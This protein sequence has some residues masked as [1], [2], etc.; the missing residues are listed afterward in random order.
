MANHVARIPEGD[1]L[2]N[3]L[4]RAGQPYVREPVRQVLR[5]LAPEPVGGRQHEARLVPGVHERANQ[6]A[7]QHEVAAFNERRGGGDDGNRGQ[8]ET[9]SWYTTRPA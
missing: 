4:A 3:P 2:V 8:S 1:D 9:T 7:R 6:R 5:S